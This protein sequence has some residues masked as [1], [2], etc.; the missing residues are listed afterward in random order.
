MRTS[1]LIISLRERITDEIFAAFGMKKNG[2]MRKLFGWLFYVPTS[3]FA[4]IF[5]E[6]DAA[7]ARGGLGAGCKVVIDYLTVDVKASGV[8][9]LQIDGPMMILSNHP[10]AYDSVA[11]GSQVSR[12]DFRIV[13]GEIPLYFALPSV[14]PLLIYAPH[15]SDTAGRML[16]LRNA[17]EHLRNGGSLLHFGAGT[18]EPDPAV[19]PGA[20]DWLSRW[21]PSVE[22]MLR[23]ASE[24]RVVLSIASGVLLKRFFQHPLTRL[25]R[26]PVARRRLAEFMQVLTQLAFPGSVK[27]E[28][29][30]RFAPPVSVAELTRQADGG[31]LMPVLIQHVRNLL[32]EQAAVEGLLL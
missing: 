18:I 9:N 8:E 7:T 1:E 11:I 5:S 28:M 17:I 4:H 24:T 25:R 29:Q 23:K 13:A 30:L 26:L 2:P 16:T 6:A 19:Q 31:R 22:I 27:A 3:R 32:S 15:A 20:V 10:G 21:S 12:K 14:S